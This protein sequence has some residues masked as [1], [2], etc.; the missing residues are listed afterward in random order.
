MLANEDKLV[1]ERPF[2]GVSPPSTSLMRAATDIGLTS[3]DLAA[4]SGFL[5]LVTPCSARTPTALFHAESVLG[6]SAFRGFPLPLAATTFAARFPSCRSPRR[7]AVD[8]RG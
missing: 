6:V 7:G 8:F 1:G 5:N 4:P 2:H 3:P